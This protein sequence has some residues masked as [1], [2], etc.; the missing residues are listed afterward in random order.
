M[1][2]IKIIND[3]KKIEEKSLNPL[4]SGHVCNNTGGSKKQWDEKSSQSP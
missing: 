2:V 3:I 4:E 1:F